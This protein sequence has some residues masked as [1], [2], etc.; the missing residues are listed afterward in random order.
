MS[1]VVVI[2]GNG[3]LGSHTVDTLAGLGHEVAAFD[4]FDG[5]QRRFE[6]SGVHE[7]TGD[8][9]DD[10]SLRRAVEGQEFV[11]HML[12][13]TTPATADVDPGFDVRTNLARTVALFDACVAAGVRSVYFA[14]TGGAIYGPQ[15][16]ETYRESDPTLPISPYAIGKL[17]IERYLEFY[18]ITRGLDFVVARISNPY[19]PRRDPRSPQGFIPIALRRI[20]EGVPV[21]RL[22]D[23]SMLRDYVYVT[24]VAIAVGRLVGADAEHRTYNIG[25]GHGL[26]VNQVLSALRE[27]T[28]VDFAVEDRPAPPTFVDRVTLDVSRYVGEFG[29]I[30]RVALADGIRETWD[31]LE[32]SQR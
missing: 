22:G 19:G 25:S 21:I 23:G 30:A 29:E 9:L 26:T 8:F 24:D 28:G 13:T 32:S 7:I 10:D 15:G 31:A 14:S 4:R 18:R 6:A 20:R 17:A 16:R 2:G 27:V 1:K 5:A 11:V 12:S 3:F